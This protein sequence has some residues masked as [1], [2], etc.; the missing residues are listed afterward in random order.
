MIQGGSI[1][2]VVVLGAGLDPISLEVQSGDTHIFEIDYAGMDLKQSLLYKIDP[3]LCDLIRCITAD[4]SAPDTVLQRLEDA[5][6][7]KNERTLLILEGISY[8]LSPEKLWSLVG[9]FKSSQK[10]NAVLLEYLYKRE[11]IAPERAAIPDDIFDAILSE[12]ATTTTTA[13]T[14]I[15]FPRYLADDIAHYTKQIGGHVHKC[16]NM[17]S[18]EMDRTHKNTYFKTKESGWI[19]VC[20]LLI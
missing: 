18:I 10:N 9:A 11:A 12:C 8:Y 20:H 17:M 1:K 3:V 5:G 2:Q 19:G 15:P 13:C 7:K 14:A 4:L 6:W 16:H